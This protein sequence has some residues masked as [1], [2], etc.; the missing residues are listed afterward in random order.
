M[1]PVVSPGEWTAASARAGL[2]QIGRLRAVLDAAQAALVGVMR[3]VFGRDTRAAVVRATGMSGAEARRAEVVADVCERVDGAAGAL[4]GGQVSAAHLA[5]LGPVAEDPGAAA[6]LARAAAQS[7]DDFARTVRRHR[8]DTDAA[9]LAERQRQ[10]RTVQFSTT[11][12]GGLRIH[13]VLTQLDGARVRAAVEQRCDE[14]WRRAHPERAASVGGHDDEP[15][16]RRLADALVELVTG[17]GVGGGCRTGV[18]V[19]VEE[20]TMQARVAGGDPVSLGDVAA[21]ASDARTELYAA[22]RSMSGA[23][24]SFGRSRRFASPLQRLA[25]IA[26]D[27]GTC[28]WPGCDRPWTR[29]DVDHRVDWESGGCTDL[30]NLRLLCTVAHH[31]HRHESG[32]Q[33][34][35]PDPPG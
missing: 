32:R 12:D 18:V 35:D 26:R 27:G 28:A 10:A 9:G 5:V 13:A 21:L 25:L 8:I 11:D 6:L 29:T 22:V 24:L 15:R 4:A 19:V 20:A 14:R 23:I 31:R 16:D 7:V 33:P 3:P 2:V 34:D 17:D 30:D 1:L